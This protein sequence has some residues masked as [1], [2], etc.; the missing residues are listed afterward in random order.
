MIF[1]DRLMTLGLP[2][3]V[4]GRHLVRQ[5]RSDHPRG[6]A[7]LVAEVQEK[8]KEYEQQYQDGLITQRE[9]YNKEVDAWTACSDKVAEEMMKVIREVR[10]PASR[11]TRSG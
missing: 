1:C 9:K 11:S 10:S 5:G 2:A 6:Q 3:G 7:P 4:Q 8:V